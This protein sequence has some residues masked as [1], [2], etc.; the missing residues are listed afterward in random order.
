MTQRP[1]NLP[2][3]LLPL[4]LAAAVVAG[5]ST[6]GEDRLGSALVAPG[7]FEFYDCQQLATQDRVQTTH[8]HELER[9][10]A[11]AKQGA[12]GG[13]VSAIAYEPDYATNH[14]TLRELHREQA[15]KKCG[16]TAA[17]PAT[18]VLPAPANPKRKR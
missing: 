10:M 11:K 15:R 16:P 13:L 18:A 7:G 12:G 5:C 1:I 9:L 2:R 17:A 8:E 3:V 14:A 4:A 6:N